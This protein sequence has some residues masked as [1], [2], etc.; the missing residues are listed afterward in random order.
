MQDNPTCFQIHDLHKSQHTEK[1]ATKTIEA[2]N[3]KLV[4]PN[5]LRASIHLFS[6][7]Q[8]YGIYIVK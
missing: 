2:L 1:R 8:C 6:E 4:P 7:V 5:F 3:M